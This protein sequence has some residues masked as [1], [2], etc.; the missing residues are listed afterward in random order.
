M[1]IMKCGV[2]KPAA[3]DKP[4]VGV[5]QGGDLIDHANELPVFSARPR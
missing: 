2:H 4:G 1:A 3:A 5:H